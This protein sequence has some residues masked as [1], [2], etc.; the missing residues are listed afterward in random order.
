MTKVFIA[1]IIQGSFRDD[2]LHDQSYRDEIRAIVRRC[3][4]EAEIICPW[5]THPEGIRY[6]PM[7]AKR[8]LIELAELAADVHLLVAHVP[9]ASMGTG[10]EMWQAHRAGIPVVTISPMVRNWVV[11]YLSSHVCGTLEEFKG[12]ASSGGLERLLGR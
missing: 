3:L 5:E 1:G 11:R 9:E 8:T 4:P 10:I 12:F 7:K 6:G 2:S